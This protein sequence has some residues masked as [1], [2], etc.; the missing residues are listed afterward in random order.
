M[1]DKRIFPVLGL[2]LILVLSVTPFLSSCEPGGEITFDN[3]YNQNVEIYYTH[4]RDNGTLDQA[5]RQVTVPAREI[6]KFG[7]T[8]LGKEWLQ[9]IE[10][11]DPSGKVVFSHD[12]KMSDLEKIQWKITILATT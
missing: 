3:Q 10:A 7:I 1:G 5:T 2:A 4:V 11:I 6:K 8:F 12:Y 9:R